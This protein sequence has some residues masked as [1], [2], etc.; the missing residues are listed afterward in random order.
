MSIPSGFHHQ[1]GKEAML[2]SLNDYLVANI[3]GGQVGG[4]SLGIG[5][6]FFFEFDNPIAPMQFPGITTAEVGLFNLGDFA[7]DDNLLGFDSSGKPIKGVKNQTLI[8]IN[9]WDSLDKSASATKNVRNLRDKV[10]FALVNAGKI[11]EDTGLPILPKIDL[12]AIDELGSPVVGQIV[13]DPSAN[14]INERFLIDPVNQQ[15]RRIKLLVRVFWFE[16][17]ENI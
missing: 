1:T 14:A 12:K 17:L 6:T 4:T 3:D 5:K 7:F 16:L 13:I 10:I 2:A 11:N 8:E 9:C 15:I